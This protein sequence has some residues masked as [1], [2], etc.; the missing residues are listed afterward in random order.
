MIQGIYDNFIWFNGVVED[1]ND[2]LKLG[3][4][5]VRCLGYHTE[6]KSLIPT[7]DLPWAM[8][9]MPIT[10][11]SMSGIGQSPIGPV[12]GTWVFGFFRDGNSCQEPVMLGAM[13]GIPEEKSN[14]KI[15]FNDPSGKYPLKEKLKEAD[16]NRLTRNEKIDKTIVKTKK[17]NVDEMELSTGVGTPDKLIEPETPYDAEYPLNRVIETEAGHIIEIDDTEDAE[18]LHIYHKSGT[19][20]EIHPD[21]SMVKKVIGNDYEIIEGS[22]SLHIK[23]GDGMNITVENNANVYVKGDVNMKTDGDFTHAVT[24]GNYTLNVKKKITMTAGEGATKIIM[25][26]EKIQANSG[27]IYLN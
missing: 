23:G 11:A 1:R 13:V 12:E 20:V 7:K 17:D 14:P 25:D 10:S 6:N 18:R 26:D 24:D 22:N 2:P 4:C 21:G 15:G 9:I 5:R 8:P 19:F 3:R 16:T 27:S